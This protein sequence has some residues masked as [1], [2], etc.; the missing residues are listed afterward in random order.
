MRI[1]ELG[2]LTANLAAMACSARISPDF[3]ALAEL[4]D[5]ELVLDLLDGKAHHSAAELLSLASAADLASWLRVQLSA[6]GFDIQRIEQAL[7]R[8]AID[9]HSP[10]TQRATL[11]SFRL[12]ALAT[13]NCEGRHFS[14]EAR[15]H[16]WHNRP[17]KP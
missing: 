13:L 12:H 9:T 8:L 16:I 3:E 1:S 14:A 5:G 11:I 15:N 6:A 2:G 7:I 17:V 4:P 10:A